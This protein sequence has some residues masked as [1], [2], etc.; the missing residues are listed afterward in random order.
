MREKY[1]QQVD[2]L[3]NVLSISLSDDRVALKGGTAINLFHRNFPRYSVDIDLCYLPIEDRDTTFAN[4]HE[5]LFVIKKEIEKN[6]S[7]KV[8]AS[9]P[10]GSNK[11]TKLLVSDGSVDIKIE[12]NFILRGCLF[13]PQM[14]P[15]NAKAAQ[16]LKR[17]LEVNCL[18]MADA[19]GGK[20]CAALDRQ[21]PR[22]FFDIK[23]L[24]ENEGITS[25]VKDSFLYYLI[26]HNRPIDELLNP[27][28]K[29]FSKEYSKE[30]VSMENTK[31]TFDELVACRE[32]LVK[33]IKLILTND[34]KKFLLSFVSNAPDWRL[35]RDEKIK[36]Y[37]SVRWKLFNQNKMEQSKASLYQ[38]NLEE[39]LWS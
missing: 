6:Y 39:L 19:Y 21:H 8:E 10:F 20:I 2:L 37:P 13:E 3:L 33:D 28:F 12:P 7:Y 9:Y 22:D 34:D 30:F 23:F 24:F 1:K 4:L 31:V 27:N 11:E 16:E 18:G 17:E 38:K 32:K 35:V 29:D 26:S 15:L 5:I 36:N 25:D 14:M